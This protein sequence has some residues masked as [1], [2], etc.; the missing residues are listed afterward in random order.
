MSSGKF[1]RKSGG[2]DSR[3]FSEEETGP[4]S[5]MPESDYGSDQSKNVYLK[6]SYEK[7]ASTV[8]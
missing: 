5:S 4:E 2:S 8:G 1:F 7:S 3:N 6:I